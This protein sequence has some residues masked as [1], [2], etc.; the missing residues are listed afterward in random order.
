MPYDNRDEQ[1]S[2]FSKENLREDAQLL[3]SIVVGHVQVL[4]DARDVLLEDRPCGSFYVFLWFVCLFLVTF[5]CL[6]NGKPFHCFR[7]L[8]GEPKNLVVICLPAFVYLLKG[9]TV[10]WLRLLES[11]QQS[12]VVKEAFAPL[13]NGLLL[14][15][16]RYADHNF[17]FSK[18]VL[19]QCPSASLRSRITLWILSG[20][21]R[22]S[23]SDE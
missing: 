12:F 22:E 18:S 1:L 15:P 5:L 20:L 16:N 23:S 6:L 11:E 7:R 9:M 2:I 19:Q 3:I 14:S 13:P 21:S 10:H 4:P 17:V 8:G